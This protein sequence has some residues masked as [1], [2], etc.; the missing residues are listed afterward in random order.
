MPASAAVEIPHLAD[1]AS[2]I[3]AVGWS[4]RDA[5][6]IAL[7]CLHSGAFTRAQFCARYHSPRSSALRAVRRLIKRGV[8]R[9]HPLPGTNQRFC[10]VQA[11]ALYR[12]LDIVNVRHRRLASGTVLY[13]RL[14][15]LDVVL[16]HPRLPWLPTE[17]DKVAY[18][19]SLR[20]DPELLPRRTYRGGR[21]RKTTR[22]FALKLP[23][24]G[25][26]DTARFVYADP[27][28]DTASAL[29]T[30]GR[31][32]RRLWEALH[33]AGV[34]VHVV[35]IGRSLAA[36]ERAEPVLASWLAPSSAEPLS[37]DEDDLLNDIETA[38]IA[39]DHT[40]LRA[41]GG[42]S[43]AVRQAAPLRRRALAQRQAS[44]GIAGYR[45]LVSQRLADD[46]LLS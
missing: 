37:P 27:G 36:Q 3:E 4:P 11:K 44:G 46:P 24:A 9:E 5:E 13:R 19:R 25:D 1:R 43:A 45:T 29:R 30:W 18:F 6:W 35:A 16:D 31:A 41:W 21:G 42:F 22:Y 14:L 40:A 33:V 26:N 10:H 32:H 15:S 39:Q 23:I 17:A 34:S 2:A 28:Y 12:A 7:V 38:L 20:I 8:A